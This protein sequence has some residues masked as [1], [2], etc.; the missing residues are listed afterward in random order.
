MGKINKAS[1]GGIASG[2]IAAIGAALGW[3]AELIGS[4]TLA[5]TGVIVWAVPNSEAK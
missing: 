1:F 5:A 4:V 2:V 3:D